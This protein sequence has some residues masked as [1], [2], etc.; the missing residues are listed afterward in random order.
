MAGKRPASPDKAALSKLADLAGKGVA[1]DRVRREV[2]N[3]VA[4]WRSGL[5][6]YD[7]RLALRERLEEM[8]DQLSEGV[9]SAQE[10]VDELDQAEK[11]AVTQ[12]RKSLAALIAARDALAAAHRSIL[13]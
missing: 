6:G 8:R 12:G 10:Q 2:E 11:A 1:P 9:E 7:E 5:I 4:D 3:I 13:I